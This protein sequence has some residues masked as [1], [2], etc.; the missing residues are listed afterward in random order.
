MGLC[1]PVWSCTALWS[2]IA[3]WFCIALWSCTAVWSCIALWSCTA[4]W[5]CTA[6]HCPAN[7]CIVLKSPEWFGRALY[8]LEWSVVLCH[9]AMV[10]W[11]GS[12]GSCK[13]LVIPMDYNG[14]YWFYF[15]FILH[16]LIR[17]CVVQYGLL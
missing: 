11:F 3:L 4:L 6:L 13:P 5:Y 1:A 2:C 9:P 16:C 8:G 15:G 12:E 7:S 14:L 17:F 10:I